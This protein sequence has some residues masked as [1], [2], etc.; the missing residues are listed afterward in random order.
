[1][2]T[3][4]T[5]SAFMTSVILHIIIALVA[6]LYLLSQTKDFKNFIGVDFL[7]PS[8]P[9]RPPRPPHIVKPPIQPVVREHSPVT[10]GLV[11]AEKRTV[12]VSP[13]R[14]RVHSQVPQD[15]SHRIIKITAPIHPRVP[16]VVSSSAPSP[17]SVT[18]A[19]PLTSDAPEALDFS[20]PVETGIPTAHRSSRRGT[21]RVSVQHTVGTPRIPG[22]SM[23]K[24]VGAARDA[25]LLD[26]VTGKIRLGNVEVPPLPRGE[27]GGEVV[28]MGR[29]IRGVLRFARIR[30]NLSDWWADSSSLNALT[31]WINERTKIKADM[32][33]EGGAIRLTDANLQKSPLVFMTGHDPALVRSHNLIGSQYG[34]GRLDNRFTPSE[35]AGLRRYLIEKGGLMVFDDCGVNAPAQA[36]IHL[37]LAQMRYVMPEYQIERIPNDHEI[38]SNYYEMGGPPVG[39]DIFWW[40]TRPQRRNFLEG[41]SIADK[42]SVITVRR[43]YMC[44]MEAVSL[45]T[46]SVHYSPGVYRFMT[47]V[48]VYAL[49][50]GSIADHTNYIPP[51]KLVDQRL[52]TTAPETVRVLSR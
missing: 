20:T 38:Y 8:K 34:G 48:A 13:L 46:R 29:D 15:V 25:D 32:N 45:P 21:A 17:R 2:S 24:S 44:A 12:M 51:D 33:V 9:Q 28:G 31:K 26:D 23:V 4:R 30:H 36:M 42:L 5:S 47:N 27:P 43:D 10:E 16:S 19:E 18:S 1:M 37:F 11:P 3:K 49:T 41:I 22:L 14:A 40:G 39:F 50:H 6:G 35:A 52:P 7:Q